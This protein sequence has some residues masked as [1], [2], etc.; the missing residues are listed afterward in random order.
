[1]NGID[2]INGRRKTRAQ[3]TLYFNSGGKLST[4]KPIDGDQNGFDEYISDPNRPCRMSITQP[5]GMVAEYVTDDQRF[6]A[7][8]TDV[9][10]YQTETLDHDVI[11][12]DQLRLILTFQQQVRILT[13]W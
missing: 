10:V 5:E 1:M 7:E 11:V 4:S 6:A 2:W 8:R 9:L 13:L 12:T 3:Q